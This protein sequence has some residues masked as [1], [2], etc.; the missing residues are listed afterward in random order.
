MKDSIAN[1]WLFGLV[2]SFILIFACYITITIS[3]TKSYKMKNEVLLI[4]EKHLGV[5]TFFSNETVDS[6]IPG[7]SENVTINAGTIQTINA[8]LS[9]NAYTAKGTCNFQDPIYYADDDQEYNVQWY[10]VTSLDFTNKSN[11][12]IEK[13]KSNTKYYYCFAKI[14]KKKY[15]KNTRYTPVYYRVRLFYKMEIPAL[16]NFLAIKVDGETSDIYDCQDD[17]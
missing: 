10:G 9:G 15:I 5:T 7:V 3:Y 6:I 13:V 8:Y 17:F 4:I 14:Q 11:V 2:I 16:Q 1:V 12:S